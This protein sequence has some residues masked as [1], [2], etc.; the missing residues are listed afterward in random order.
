MRVSAPFKIQ[1]IR[2]ND[3]MAKK[4]AFQEKEALLKQGKPFVVHPKEAAKV[5]KECDT[6]PEIL[7]AC[8]VVSGTLDTAYALQAELK[9]FHGLALDKDE[10]RARDAFRRVW[11]APTEDERAAVMEMAEKFAAAVRSKKP[12]VWGAPV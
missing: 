2:Q 4:T 6:S 5:F 11:A 8:I 1:N 10:Q 3:K 12:L 7:L 9:I